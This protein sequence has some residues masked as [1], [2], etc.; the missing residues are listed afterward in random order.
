MSETCFYHIN[1]KGI[2]NRVATVEEGITKANAEGYLWLNYNQPAKEELAKLIGL[3]NIHPLSV[4]DCFDDN[5]IPKIEEFPGY[6]F[7]LFN[8]LG[9]YLI[10][11]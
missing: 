7:I 9:S 8:T 2:L 1:K 3:L 11:G 5:Q 6:T 10:D 4:E